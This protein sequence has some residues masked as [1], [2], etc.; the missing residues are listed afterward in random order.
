M[1]TMIYTSDRAVKKE[2]LENR[3][4]EEKTR[5]QGFKQN[6]DPESEQWFMNCCAS[7]DLNSFV[8]DD[9]ATIYVFKEPFQLLFPLFF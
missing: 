4:M 1:K 2:S 5:K 3:S 7:V 8:S 9:I 6:S